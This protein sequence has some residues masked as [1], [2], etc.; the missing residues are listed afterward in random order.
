[1]EPVRRLTKPTYLTK[2]KKT[3]ALAATEK[4]IKAAEIKARSSMKEQKSKAHIT[5]GDEILYAPVPRLVEALT[6]KTVVGAAAAA[7]RR[8]SHTAVWTK[9][10][11]IYTF[12]RGFNG[13]LGQ[14]QLG[15]RRELVPRLAQALCEA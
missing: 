13:Q 12:G 5:G 2:R 14:S 3:L 1:M 8:S 9:A 6:G 15:G 11:D 4:G 7:G 10:G